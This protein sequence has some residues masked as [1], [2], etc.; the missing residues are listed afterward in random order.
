MDKI[1]HFTEYLTLGAALFRSVHRS[2]RH[3]LYAAPRLSAIITIAC[4]TAY[5]ILDEWH[6]SFTGRTPDA[7]D[8]LVDFVGIVCGVLLIVSIR[9]WRRKHGG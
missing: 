5:G 6:Q 1:P 9:T 4:G 7:M 8:A 2:V 3:H